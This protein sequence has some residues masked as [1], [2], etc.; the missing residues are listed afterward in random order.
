MRTIINLV[1]LI[2]STFILITSPLAQSSNSKPNIVYILVDNIGWGD[3]SIYGG[4]VP[5]QRIDQLA[6][7]GMRFNNYN[8][9]VQCTPTRS[10]IMTGRMPVRTGNYKIPYPGQGPAGMAPWEFTIAEL[11]SSGGYTTALYGKWHLGEVQGRLPNDQGFDEWWGYPNS[12]DE[13]GYSSYALFN[14]MVEKLLAEHKG[15]KPLDIPPYILEGKKGE[16]SKQVMPFDM[17]LRPIIDE[18][19]NIPKTIDFIKRSAVAKKPFFVFLAYSEMHPPVIA[20]PN[21]AGKSPMRGGPYADIIAEM[22]FRVGQV[23]DAIKEAGIEENTIVVLTSDNA[24]WTFGSSTN[25][26]SNGP[27]RGDFFNT[28]YEGSMRVPGMIRW[29]GK[30]AAGKISNDIVAAT[31]WLPTIAGLTG[32]SNLVPTDRPIDGIDQS[33]FI[34]G[35]SECPRTSYMFFGADAELMS[36][37]WYYY[38]TIFRYSD[39]ADKPY[40][41]PQIPI[42]YDLSSDPQEKVDLFRSTMTMGW[43]AAPVFEE[44]AKYE[45]SVAQ[46]PN[47][48]PGE[49]F[50]GYKTK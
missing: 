1:V 49:E 15:E 31:D 17:E 34:L 24:T 16:L 6:N 19:Y 10:A 23:L 50:K 26:G 36:V 25:G 9:E 28:P 21:F 32:L 47:I 38:K 12:A 7:E 4:N 41:A 29:P 11:L 14:V 39:G 18:K 35:K 33:S 13:A 42:F 2:I 30:I 43:V 44:I 22:D 37:K 48:K 5:T 8:V 46:F 20:N 3:F 45:K 27:W 40:L